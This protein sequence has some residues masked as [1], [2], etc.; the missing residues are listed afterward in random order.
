MFFLLLSVFLFGTALIVFRRA[1]FSV[2]RV[3]LFFILALFSSGLSLLYLVSDYFTGEGVNGAVIYLLQTGVEGAGLSDFSNLIVSVSFL[4]LAIIFFLSLTVYKSYHGLFGKRSYSAITF[5]LLF[6][7]VI[8][9]PAIHDIYK[10]YNISFINEE[11]LAAE[12]R[13]WEEFNRETVKLPAETNSTVISQTAGEF[14]PNSA[15]F[16]H[17]YKK[18][19]LEKTGESK[20][21]VYIYTESLEETYSNE[22]IFP[23]L[24]PNLNTLKNKGIHFS[25]LYQTYGADYTN[26]GIVSSQCG[27]PLI[28]PS[29]GNTLSGLDTYLPL[30]TCLG[31][32]LHKEGYYL[33]YYGGA[34]LKFA[35]KGAFYKTHGF[36]EVNGLKE[37][38]PQLLDK[39]YYD[40]WGLYDDTILNL[41]YNKF[42]ELSQSKERFGL[43]ALTLDTHHPYGR[44]ARECNGMKYGDGKNTMLN[45]VACADYLV[46]QFVKRI[47]ESPYGKNTVIV[48]ASD[49][50]GLKNVASDYLSKTERKN[51]LLIIPPDLF[52]PQEISKFSLTLNNSTT[53]LP[54]LGYSASIGLGRNVLDGNYS[55]LETQT[56][57]DN[58]YSWRN[59]LIRFW[60]FPKI[61]SSVQ[62]DPV[63]KVAFIDGRKFDIPIL[64]QIDD[65]LQT[66]LKFQFSV[67]ANLNLISQLSELGENETFVLI[68]NCVDVKQLNP[69]AGDNGFCMLKGSKKN[70]ELVPLQEIYNLDINQIKNLINT[71]V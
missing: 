18:P 67:A 36:D 50:L 63:N 56:I 52:A 66:T 41:T 60:Y 22:E 33:S 17:H 37:L 2:W 40:G 62:V 4:F 64:I 8:F 23:N 55:E 24:T 54:F 51:R 71:K 11:V 5:L 20:N 69:R 14:L 39:T 35:G 1:Y 49:H 59:S 68:D 38:L 12:D 32:L 53:I 31:D 28:S 70:N 7:S 10:F 43:F 27:L 13:A 58:V 26:A 47:M 16:Y 48:I 3:I 19:I 21:L 25:N 15:D 46:G 9:N 6:F 45:A 65:D 42:L 30:A 34:D 29:H 61:R 44:V 57:K